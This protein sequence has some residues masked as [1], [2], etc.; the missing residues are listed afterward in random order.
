MLRCLDPT[1][2]L[3]GKLL[4]VAFVKDRISV[5]EQQA[6]LDDKNY[7][8]LK[9]LREAPDNLQESVMNDFIAA[10]RSCGQEHVANIFIP[11]SD[12][13]PMSVDHRY[14]IIIVKKLYSLKR[15]VRTTVATSHK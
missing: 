12:K 7:A 1:N 4:S 10:L 11:E 9:A 3:L 13:V 8:L 5:I 6:T 15:F 14:M 2:E